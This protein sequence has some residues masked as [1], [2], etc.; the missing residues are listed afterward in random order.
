ML[1][2]GGANTARDFYFLR[3]GDQDGD[4]IQAAHDN[5]D[6][7]S[8]PGQEDFNGNTIGDACED[9]DGDGILD[10]DEIAMGT[11]PSRRRYR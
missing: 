3:A 4:G 5:C 10:A 6:R 11:D 2:T 1:W 8:N 7:T 9:S